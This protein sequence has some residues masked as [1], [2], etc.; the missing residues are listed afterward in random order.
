MYKH[1][2][3][4]KAKKHRKMYTCR[5]MGHGFSYVKPFVGSELENNVVWEGTLYIPFLKAGEKLYIK[6]LNETV[7]IDSI[8]KHS[9]GSAVYQLNR[10]YDLV[11]DEF[12]EESKVE[13][14]SRKKELNKIEEEFKEN[15]KNICKEESP[16]VKAEPK[17][18]WIDWLLGS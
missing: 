9:N 7:T 11:E 4:V 10:Y 14:E 5:Y 3:V 16:I 18:S 15:L 17:K 2:A 13:A 12:T 8:L 1:E 6:D